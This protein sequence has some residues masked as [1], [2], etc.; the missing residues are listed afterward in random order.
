[1]AHE[2]VVLQLQTTDDLL[3]LLLKETT[4]FS[5]SPKNATIRDMIQ[6]YMLNRSVEAGQSPAT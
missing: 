5:R 4:P 6:W 1:M 2:T 3:D